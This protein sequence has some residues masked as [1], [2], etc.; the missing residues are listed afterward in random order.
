M[1]KPLTLVA[2]VATLGACATLAQ[3]GSVRSLVLTPGKGVSFHMGSKHGV[4]LFTP[5]KGVCNLTITIAENPDMDGMAQSSASRVKMAV[6]PGNPA[7]LD[8][9]EGH[10]LVFACN[11][12]GQTMN[13]DMPEN[14]KYQPKG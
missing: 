9:A 6:M 12:D 10:S 1:M 11:A 7:S 5:G 3:A 2:T 8:T 4:T 13:L 14:F